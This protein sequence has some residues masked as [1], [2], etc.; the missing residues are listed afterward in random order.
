MNKIIVTTSYHKKQI[1][2]KAFENKEFFDS[3]FISLKELK[4]RLFF[5]YDK[6]AIY[7][8]MKKYNL[9]VD[10]ALMYLNNLYYISE[11]ENSN[12]KFLKEIYNDLLANKLIVIDELYKEYSIDKNYIFYNMIDNLEINLVKNKLE[13]YEVVNDMTA[14]NNDFIVNRFDFISDEINY[15]LNKICTL[16]DNGISLNNIKIVGSNSDYDLALNKLC[17]LFNLPF[18]LK[19]SNI[20]STKIGKYFINNLNILPLG[21]IIDNMRNS[22]KASN[23]E[24]IINKIVNI[25]NEYSWVD[26][27]DSEIRSLIEYDLIKATINTDNKTNTINCVSLEEV[28]SSDY[29]F[30]IGMNEG[31]IPAVKKDTNYLNDTVK[32]QLNLLTVKEENKNN[33]EFIKEKLKTLP[34]LYISFVKFNSSGE[35]YPSSIINDMQMK[36][37][38]DKLDYSYSKNYDRLLLGSAL[39]N[40]RKYSSV[41][42]DLKNLFN[43]YQNLNYL[44]YDNKFNGIDNKILLNNLK[45]RKNLVLSYSNLDTMMKCSFRYYLDNILY[46][47]KF[48]RNF[49]AIIGSYYHYILEKRN[50]NDFEFERFT[51]NFFN[52]YELSLLEKTLLEPLKEE[53]KLVLE[54]TDYFEDLSM[55]KNIEKEEK[56][57]FII[58]DKIDITIKGFIDKVMTYNENDNNYIALIDYKTGAFNLNLN[59][60]YNGFGLQLPMYAYLS[61]NSVKYSKY[62]VSG[63]YVAPMLVG[64][65]IIKDNT[66]YKSIVK[67]K[68]R[69]IG[70]SNQNESILSKFDPTY[71]N[72]L[73][74]KGMKLTSKGFSAFSKTLTSNDIN[75]MTDYV[76]KLIK[77][78]IKKILNGDFDINP[79]IKDNKNVSCSYCK[80]KDICNKKYE[81][82][83]YLEN[84]K[85]E[86]FLGGDNNGN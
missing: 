18:S 52:D 34:N 20:L 72:S 27:I 28:N 21:E 22:F 80:Y 32:S 66:D 48:E 69:Y 67:D 77:S 85:Y 76:D 84:K 30:I 36:V 13:N 17:G 70:Y 55:Y 25:L 65:E 74:I 40:Y 43:N 39:D 19:K 41:N 4:E 82:S 1:L 58:K 64:R 45:N 8:L 3:K 63:L 49:S 9:I 35:V 7:Y 60:L 68:M 44:T 57:E 12:I 11:I 50:E 37:I 31:N 51:S 42:E 61:K 79:K 71:S 15:L 10:N 5:K 78:S 56:I 59:D 16:I 54:I 38:S 73:M 29:V 53:L 2:Q 23:D 24:V 81:D 86:E 83:I 14:I 62:K 75:N 33:I 47:N 26:E 6:R 46:L